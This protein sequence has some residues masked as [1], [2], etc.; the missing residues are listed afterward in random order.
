MAASI[1][2]TKPSGSEAVRTAVS[3][4]QAGKGV[5][6]IGTPHARYSYIFNGVT[7]SVISSTVN[8]STPTS[9]PRTK[10]AIRSDPWA[11][12]RTTLGM[13]ASFAA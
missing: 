7:A 3:A 13:P 1:A 9:N 5:P 4:T 2:A 11:G 8:G 6:T 10:S 12:S